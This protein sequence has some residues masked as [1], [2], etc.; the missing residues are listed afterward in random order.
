MLFYLKMRWRPGERCLDVLADCYGAMIET[1]P[2]W[3]LGRA[4]TGFRIDWAFFTPGNRLSNATYYKILAALWLAKKEPPLGKVPMLGLRH[5]R[6]TRGGRPV[7]FRFGRQAAGREAGGQGPRA[8]PPGRAQ[9]RRPRP[10]IF[11]N[12]GVLLLDLAHPAAVPAFEN[13]F[14]VAARY[15]ERPE[16]ITTNAPS[17]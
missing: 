5:L 13:A 8:N 7:A 4:H 6:G 10:E 16:I 15:P 11:F 3:D 1:L 9:A 17:T 14:E 2:A 12:A